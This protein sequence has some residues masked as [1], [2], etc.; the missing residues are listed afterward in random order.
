MGF[1][2]YIKNRFFSNDCQEEEGQVLGKEPLQ[3][4]DAYRIQYEKWLKTNNYQ[5]M[6]QA[7]QTAFPQK[8]A[9]RSKK[10]QAICFLMIPTINGFTM[11][12]DAARWEQDDFKYL[13]EYLKDLLTQH[14]AYE[15]CTSLQETIQYP[16]HK[17]TI[18]RHSL[19]TANTETHYSKILIRLCYTNNKITTLKFCASC[20]PGKQAAFNLFLEK[21]AAVQ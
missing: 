10:D 14:F 3:R 16:K 9:C 7:I 5:A 17:E 6:L 12:Y 18:E 2:N 21:M 19:K 1:F 8:C 11:R 4:S 13:F 20:T 15:E